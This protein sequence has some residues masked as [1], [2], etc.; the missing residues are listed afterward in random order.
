MSLRERLKARARPSAPF[1]LRMADDSEAKTALAKAEMELRRTIIA[2]GEGTD[3]AAAAEQKVADAREQ[4]R[5]CYEELTLTALPPEDLEALIA[6]HPPTKDQ[7][8][9][10]G[11]ATWN[12]D[13]FRPAL[14]AATVEG[15]VS[16]E[17]W[18]DMYQTGQ[19]NLGEFRRLYFACLDVNNRT[20]DPHLGKG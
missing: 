17:D 8:E 11:D 9:Q 13:T 15:D 12:E 7:R 19:L 14:L 16:E 3:E 1:H 10:D 6:E 5:A 4:V 2:D 20:S 18:A